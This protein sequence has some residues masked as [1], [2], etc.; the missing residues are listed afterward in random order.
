MNGATA[1]GILRF[2]SGMSVTFRVASQEV[3]AWR[4]IRRPG[5]K[6]HHITSYTVPHLIHRCDSLLSGISALRSGTE[7][8]HLGGR[9]IS[10]LLVKLRRKPVNQNVEMF[11][12]T[13]CSPKW[14]GSYIFCCEMERNV[15]P[16][17]QFHSCSMTWWGFTEPQTP[18]L[19][20]TLLLK[21]KVTLSLKIRHH[22]TS[23]ILSS[24]WR[25]QQKSY[26]LCCCLASKLS[27]FHPWA[28]ACGEYVR[29]TAVWGKFDSR[30]HLLSGLRGLSWRASLTCLK[31]SSVARRRPELFP[32][33]CSF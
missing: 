3:V 23:A 33:R 27:S 26:C 16:F 11:A 4:Q 21:L 10:R 29:Q 18:T 25:S 6:G 2:K 19:W 22:N 15:L 20:L 5:G 17:M 30:L 31:I 28:S 14:D 12:V 13:V 1:S 7:K 24:T 9:W 32:F 8:R